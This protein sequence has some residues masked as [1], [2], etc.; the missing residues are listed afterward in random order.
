M[1]IVVLYQIYYSLKSLV[2]SAKI[3]DK[4]RFI[5]FPIDFQFY[6]DLPNSK[7]RINL[8]VSF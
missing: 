5:F 3:G 1:S 7:N 2:L 4:A 6:H 8:N